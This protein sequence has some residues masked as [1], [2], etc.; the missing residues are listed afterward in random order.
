MIENLSLRSRIVTLLA[1]VLA[2]GLALGIATLVLHAGARIRAEAE[3]ATRLG[4]DFVE[5]AL[6]RAATAPDPTA[7]LTRLVAQAQKLRHVRIYLE[8]EGAPPAQIRG[9]ARRAPGWFAALATPRETITRIAAPAPMPGA[10]LIAADPSDEIAEIWEEILGLA[11]GGALVALAAFALVFIAISRTLAPVSALAQGLQ[12]LEKGER[13]LRVPRAGSPEFALITDRINALA[14][15]LKRLDAENRDLLFRMIDVQETERRD[16]ARDLHD[17]MGPF[18]FAI[19]AGVGALRRK[20]PGAGVEKDCEM[21]D[22]QIAALQGVNRRILARLRPAALEELGLAGALDA[23]VRGWRETH[24]QATITLAVADCALDEATA[25]VAYRI[26]Q[27]GL[28]NALRH[29]EAQRVSI[30]VRPAGGRELRVRVDDDGTG[31]KAGWRQGHGLRGMSE[32]IAA[33][34]GRLTFESGAPKGAV[35]EASLPLPGSS[36]A[37]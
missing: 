30:D 28:T 19:R 22:E 35:L 36:G 16:I 34:G 18:L 6:A 17:E 27:E 23:L 26:A 1:S 9:G 14:D 7:E 12:A 20:P 33:L 21:L 31:L 8:S 4:V 2:M 32:R 24:P 13:G 3:A 15:A 10:V 25:L 37:P 11:L 5:S 29:A